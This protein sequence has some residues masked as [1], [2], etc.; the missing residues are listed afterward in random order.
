[1]NPTVDNVMI[2]EVTPP[3][4]GKS[5]KLQAGDEILKINDQT[6]RGR[7]AI[8]LMKYFKSIKP[9]D[10]KVYTIRRGDEM[11]VVDVRK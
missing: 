4:P 6:V 11:L 8:G 9:T 10:P 5:C 1:M 3:L 2:N 7:K